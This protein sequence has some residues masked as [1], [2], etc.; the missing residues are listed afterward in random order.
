M[1]NATEALPF[2]RVITAVLQGSP[3]CVVWYSFTLYF[4]VGRDDHSFTEK[5]REEGGREGERG[6]RE[7]AREGREGGSEREK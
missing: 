2:S 3:H 1:Y 7:R 6:G 4:D 5:E